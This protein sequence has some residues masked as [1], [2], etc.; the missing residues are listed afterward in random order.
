MRE[1]CL[2]LGQR[3][4]PRLVHTVER[5]P[6]VREVA[7]EVD[8]VRI[9]ARVARPAVGIEHRDDPEVDA[10]RRLVRELERDPDAAGLVAVDAPDDEDGNPVR[11]TG[12]DERNRTA[13]R[14]PAE[15]RLR[16]SRGRRKREKRQRGTDTSCAPPA[17]PTRGS[18]VT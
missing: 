4:R 3:P 1:P 13:E 9:A 14:R 7:I 17:A 2:D 15:E 12:F 6:P 10:G 8:A 18:S 16:R 11:V 5:T